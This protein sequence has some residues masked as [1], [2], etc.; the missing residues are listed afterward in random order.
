MGKIY[1]FGIGGTG[2]RV[3]KSLTMLLAAGVKIE[4][5]SIVPIIVDPDVAGADLTRTVDIMHAYNNVREKLQFTNNVKNRFFQ[6]EIKELLPNFRMDLTNTQNL[7]FKDYIGL[8]NLDKAN[9]ALVKMLFSDENLNSDMEVGFKGNPNIGS[10][11]LN[12][13]TQSSQ[14]LSFASDFKEEDRIFIISSI[15]GG[16]G[17][18]GFPVLLKNLRTLKEKNEKIPSADAIEK[19]VIGAITVL[20]YFG[21]KNDAD[22][23]I[24]DATFI[25]KT[26]AALAYYNQ[27]METLDVLYY[28]GDRIQNK[29]ENNEGGVDQKNYAHLIELIAALSVIDFAENHTSISYSGK[30]SK[31][32]GVKQDA[33]KLILPDLCDGTYDLM[34]EPLTQFTLFCKFMNE[35]LKTSIDS[36]Q[37]WTKKFEEKKVFGDR[38]VKSNFTS[39]KAHYLEWLNEMADNERGFSPFELGVNKDA[40]F[41]LVKGCDTK[42][43]FSNKSNYDLF[44][45]YLNK[46][47]S[48]LKE[49]TSIE[50][51][52]IELFYNATKELVNDKIRL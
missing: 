40:V 35:H 20:P 32:F 25:S 9:Q 1:I 19:A 16:T 12:K 41:S 29:Y 5:D 4:T 27:N 45:S 39:M 28:L 43:V 23:Q 7:L 3:I 31:E 50:Q 11:V 18:S 37:E 52:L 36:K 24:D 15:F 42:R 8:S 49:D 38:F 14:F 30:E 21:V 44:D 48:K 34:V 2:S 46:Q 47:E 13:F 22:S 17:A 10:V 33:S 51:R 26:K 6:T